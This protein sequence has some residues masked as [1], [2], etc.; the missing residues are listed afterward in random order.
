M[1]I[2]IEVW[3]NTLFIIKLMNLTGNNA[4]MKYEKNYQNK[5]V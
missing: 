2:L 4:R 1:I 5:K 3:W